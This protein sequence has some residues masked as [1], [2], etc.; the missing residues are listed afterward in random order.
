MALTEKRARFCRDSCRVREMAPA[1]GNRQGPGSEPFS[2]P[3]W[4]LKSWRVRPMRRKK[5][6]EPFFR[7]FDG[8]WYVQLGKEQIKLA[9]GKDN[10][11]AAWR[12]YFRVMASRGPACPVAP[13]R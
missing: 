7:N 4:F 5:K 8:W 2:S 11:D 1:G 3:R 13:L 6:P 12:A 10:E 9:Q